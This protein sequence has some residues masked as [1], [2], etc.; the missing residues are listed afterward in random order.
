MQR[1]QLK[2][3]IGTEDEE[4]SAKGTN[5]EDDDADTDLLEPV[6][7]TRSRPAVNIGRLSG[8]GA[9]LPGVHSAQLP[10]CVLVKA[11]LA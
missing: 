11:V 2:R 10:P 6:I 7:T 8:L 5:A 1:K 4:P 3:L 9:P